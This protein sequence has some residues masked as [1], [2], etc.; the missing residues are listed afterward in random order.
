MVKKFRWLISYLGVR[1]TWIL[2]LSLIV[3]FVVPSGSYYGPLPI[4]KRVVD[5]IIEPVTRAEAQELEFLSCL[6]QGGSVIPNLS[7]VKKVIPE[8]A[9]IVQRVGDL[10]YPRIRFGGD[11]SEYTYFV[12]TD[13]IE[14]ELISSS[15]CGEYFVGVMKNY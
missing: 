13:R 7:T 8:D 2:S 1:S 12:S 10:L 14:Q 3:L 15:K 6:E 11:N 9:Y 4:V 5:R